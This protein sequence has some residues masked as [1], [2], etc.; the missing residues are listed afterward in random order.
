MVGKGWLNS[1]L[2][3]Q[4]DKTLDDFPPP[5]SYIMNVSQQ[6][7]DFQCGSNMISMS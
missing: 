1:L 5:A 2:S 3:L 6:R 4:L 7:E